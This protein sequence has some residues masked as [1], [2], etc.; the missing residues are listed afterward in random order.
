MLFIVPKGLKCLPS[1]HNLF[2]TC[3]MHGGFP[4][5]LEGTVDHGFGRGSKELGIPTANFSEKDVLRFS[6]DLKAGIYLGWAQVDSGTVE[7]M[8]MSVG[9]N[10]FYK[11]EKKAVEVHIL[12]EFPKEFYGS[13]MRAIALEYLR[14]EMDFPSLDS[15][16][17]AI[18]G[19]IAAANSR[20]DSE[21]YLKYKTHSFFC[22]G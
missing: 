20:L 21:E 8:V 9:W 15:L 6:P 17:T 5:L 4:Y 11:N 2:R 1:F 22:I 18:K 3:T 12:A 16:I 10:P 19:D 14:P 7:K 13:H